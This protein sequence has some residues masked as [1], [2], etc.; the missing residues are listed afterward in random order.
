MTNDDGLPPIDRV[1]AP[2]WDATRDRRLLL[3][4]CAP[5]GHVQHYPRPVCTV[6][7]AVGAYT[8]IE[9]SGLGTVDSYTVVHRAPTPGTEVPY[10]V[11][12]V[13]LA[14]G[15]VLLTRLDNVPDDASAFD[16]ELRLTWQPLPDGRHLPTFTARAVDPAP[17]PGV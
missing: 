6:C 5:C 10:T 2:W 3:Q 17:R 12:R 9:A 4:K 1:T 8:W 7:G 14:E 11:A 15:P 16:A 13:R